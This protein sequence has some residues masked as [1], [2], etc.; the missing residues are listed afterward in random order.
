MMAVGTDPDVLR[1]EMLKHNLIDLV[2]NNKLLGPNII[3]GLTKNLDTVTRAT[4]I[5]I[6]QPERLLISTI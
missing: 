3:P 6:K 4:K 1:Q 2:K 5:E